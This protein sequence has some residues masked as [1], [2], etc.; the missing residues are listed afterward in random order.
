M[1]TFF[2]GWRRKAGV[3][4]LV[5]AL[6][7]TAGWV[8]SFY[9]V[10]VVKFQSG[11]RIEDS[12]RSGSDGLSLAR[13]YESDDAGFGFRQPIGSLRFATASRFESIPVSIAPL[14][15]ESMESGGESI[16]PNAETTVDELP[17]EDIVIKW[18][19]AWQWCGFSVGGFEIVD[20]ELQVG[21]TTPYWGIVI[22]LTLLSAYLLL[23][24]LRKRLP[25]AGQAHA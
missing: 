7:F 8:R 5:M 25:T 6:A 17:D 1:H 19:W 20:G 22:P 18:E 3:A 21:V 10:D 23:F 12:L 4:T 14:V 15:A 2:H 16:A 13:C 24:P 11:K 9:L